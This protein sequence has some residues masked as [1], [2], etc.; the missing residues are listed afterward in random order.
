MGV[1]Y[2]QMCIQ[3]KTPRRLEIIARW[4]PL[5]II[6]SSGLKEVW[7][8]RCWVWR[9][10]Q[11]TWT[12]LV[13]KS[14]N[15]AEEDSLDWSDSQ[16]SILIVV[17]NTY[18]CFLI[19]LLCQTKQCNLKDLR[20]YARTSLTLILTELIP[21]LTHFR[22]QLSGFVFTNIAE[23]RVWL[24]NWVK[25]EERIHVPR[26]PVTLFYFI[27]FFLRF[28]ISIIGIKFALVKYDPLPLQSALNR[29]TFWFY[30]EGWGGVE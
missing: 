3:I 7:N 14:I 10:H 1:K 11:N 19:E 20:L 16:N 15:N 28:L 17:I 26:A 25:A 23:S 9:G 8:R 12:I 13:C 6:W 30:V 5:P 21:S 18:S 27:L 24:E 4:G 29:P 22:V 2:S